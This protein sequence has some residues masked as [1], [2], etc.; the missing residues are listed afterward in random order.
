MK[1]TEY[2]VLKNTNL[3]E[4]GFSLSL[5]RGEVRSDLDG[6]FTAPYLKWN[7]DEKYLKSLGIVDI[8]ETLAE[9][10]G[11]EAPADEQ[12]EFDTKDETQDE[13]VGDG[14]E[15]EDKTVDE[16]EDE[17]VDETEDETEDDEEDFPDF[18]AMSFADIKK[19]AT[20]HNVDIAGLKKKEDIIDAILD[21]LAE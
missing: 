15:T 16:T 3:S 13:T 8:D 10:E 9:T 6:K 14:D 11:E 21:E 18:D 12:S 2:E 7:C 17:T 5:N 20:D 4:N 19:Y 1:A